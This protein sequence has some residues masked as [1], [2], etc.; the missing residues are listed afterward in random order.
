MDTTNTRIVKIKSA[1]LA[2]VLRLSG[3]PN[4]SSLGGLLFW[5]TVDASG[6]LYISDWSNNRIVFVNVSGA[7][8]T[9]VSTR[10]GFT[11]T[12]SPKAAAL[13]AAG[14]P[15]GSVVTIAPSTLAAGDGDT[16]VAVAITV[17]ATGAVT[18]WRAAMRGGLAP[19]MAGM[20]LLP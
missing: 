8:L 1:R 18:H 2:S 12:D 10:Q 17:P 6:N 13:M 9:F 14:A 11:S 3:L 7:P 20:F 4:P 16:N 19:I 5:V 15:T